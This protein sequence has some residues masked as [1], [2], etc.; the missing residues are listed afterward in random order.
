MKS[1]CQC[2][3]DMSSESGSVCSRIR[4]EDCCF[5]HHIQPVWACFSCV[6]S[7]RALIARFGPDVWKTRSLWTSQGGDLV[8]W[9][10]FVKRRSGKSD[11]DWFG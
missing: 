5:S 1:P 3:F 6:I 11:G 10:E 4:S 7:D 9:G 8:K 2:G